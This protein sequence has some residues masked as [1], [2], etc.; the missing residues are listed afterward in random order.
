VAA[1]RS[2]DVKP[3]R[4]KVLL[5]RWQLTGF[6]KLLKRG[7]IQSVR[8]EEDDSPRPGIG[9]KGKVQAERIRRSICWWPSFYLF[10]K[11]SPLFPASSLSGSEGRAG[12]GSEFKSRVSVY[13]FEKEVSCFVP[14][15]LP[16][17]LEA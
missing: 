15:E 13:R 9:R 8:D 1:G 6:Q 14:K 16:K 4:H 10:L 12:S 7:G 3:S 11:E 5:K 2:R 17:G